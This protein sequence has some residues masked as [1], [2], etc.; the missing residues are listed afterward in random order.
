MRDFSKLKEQNEIGGKRK[1]KGQ[2]TADEADIEGIIFAH[3]ECLTLFDSLLDINI[4]Y[5]W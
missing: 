4:H 2:G 3:R 1:K 5:F